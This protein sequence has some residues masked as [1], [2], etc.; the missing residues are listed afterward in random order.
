MACFGLFDWPSSGSFIVHIK[1]KIISG[2]G[3]S[4]ANVKY[5]DCIR[6]SFNY[7]LFYI[8]ALFGIVILI[9]ALYLTLVKERPCPEII[10]FFVYALLLPDN[11]QSYRLKHVIEI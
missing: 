8:I 5:S 1:R 4:F 6:I 7:Y 3:L 10:F 11:G 2:Q 9:R